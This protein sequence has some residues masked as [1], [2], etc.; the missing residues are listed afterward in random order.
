MI[1]SIQ[2][3]N[4]QS[5]KDTYIEFGDGLNVLTGSSRSGKS[6]VRRA[7]MWCMLNRPTGNSIVSWWNKKKDRLIG[8]TSVTVT[9]D[10][11]TVITRIKSPELNGYIINGKTLE[12]VGTNVPEEI[13]EAFNISDVNYSGQFDAPYLVSQSAGYVAQYLNAIVN[14]ED[15]DYYQKEVE[16]LKRAC[17]REI[18]TDTENAIKYKASLTEYDWLD[19][20]EKTIEFIKDKSSTLSNTETVLLNIKRVYEER[21]RA[22]KTYSDLV[23]VVPSATQKIK[24]IRT[25]IEER[26]QLEAR[27]A[28]V[29]ELH[30]ARQEA[31]KHIEVPIAEMEAVIKKIERLD[32]AKKICYNDLV[33][34]KKK[35]EEYDS[36]VGIFVATNRELKDAERELDLVDICPLCG[37]KRKDT[38]VVF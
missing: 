10:N 14:L 18:D 30:S 25:L 15:A 4:F 29:V 5:H 21:E 31:L 8:E 37:N 2:I 22:K 7:L 32:R 17:Q 28:R 35:K 1:K 23:S 9:L 34:L 27:I 16:S 26:H 12:A 38:K 3:K 11:D 6:T 19:S 33:L 36:A 24:A 13:T 20:A